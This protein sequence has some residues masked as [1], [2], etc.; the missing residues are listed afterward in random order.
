MPGAT[1]RANGGGD[2][3]QVTL[4]HLR[5]LLV[6]DHPFQRHAL[7]S[8][9]RRLGASD[10][11]EAEN[12]VA[13]LEQ[14]QLADPPVDVVISD[15]DMPG[16]DGIEFLRHM[17][18]SS[19]TASVILATAVDGAVL[20]S[21]QAMAA[22][23][24]VNLLGVIAKPISAQ[25]LLEL[26]GR[27]GCLT[28]RDQPGPTCASFTAADLRA[29][30]ARGEFFPCFQ[31]KVEIRSLRVAGFEALARW[32]HRQEGVV[33]PDCF[34]PAMEQSGLVSDLFWQMLDRS[35]DFTARLR[36]TGFAGTVAVNLSPSSLKDLELVARMNDVVLG[37]GLQP[38]DVLLELTE[39]A[40]VSEALGPALENL[41]RLRLRGFGL[42]IDDCGTG[43]S[44]FQQLARLPFTELKID[45]SFVGSATTHEASRILV[46]ASLEIAKKLKL[47]SVAEGVESREQWLLLR[48]LGCEQAQGFGIARP[49]A[50][51]MATA[52]LDEWNRSPRL[53]PRSAGG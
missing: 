43:Y 17:G 36:C 3:R 25:R 48:E 6:E 19:R 38:R 24:G 45:K 44:S 5:F 4:S 30:L 32:Q 27:H 8:T 23:Y 10:C 39:S 14:F 22:A 9:L 15:V 33:T 2:S 35:V 29:G 31:P 40:A 41:A 12:G 1:W 16:M 7:I 52:W 51:D 46:E 20:T 21:V 49:M 37:A 26:I 11:L 47:R 53:P 34:L 18:Q 28:M 42:S 13:A 50:A